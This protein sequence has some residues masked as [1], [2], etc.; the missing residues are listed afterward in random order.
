MVSDKRLPIH[1]KL[2]Y[3]SRKTFSD[4]LSFNCKKKKEKNTPMLYSKYKR[5]LRCAVSLY[6]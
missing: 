1:E 3:I 5:K 4:I 2:L 6:Q